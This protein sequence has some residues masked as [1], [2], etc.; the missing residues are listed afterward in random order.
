[1]GCPYPIDVDSRVGDL[2][3]G[4][5]VF[6]L[7]QALTS[8]DPLEAGYDYDTLSLQ[9]VAENFDMDIDKVFEICREANIKLPF[10][11]STKLHQMQIETLYSK[12]EYES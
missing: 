8:I 5:Q 7:L 9:E 11:R 2:L 1:M 10:G 12:L 3:T 4:E 6:T